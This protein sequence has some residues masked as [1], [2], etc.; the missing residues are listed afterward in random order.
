[1]YTLHGPLHERVEI[2]C[3][4]IAEEASVLQKNLFKL[5][6]SGRYLLRAM[7]FFTNYAAVLST[8][9]TIEFH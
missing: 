3:H 9:Q 7:S 6:S 5:G 2:S 1:M 8:V 4:L